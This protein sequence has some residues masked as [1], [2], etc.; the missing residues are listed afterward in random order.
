MSIIGGPHPMTC[1]TTI[2]QGRGVS[3][4]LAEAEIIWPA[5]LA[6]AMEGELRPVYGAAQ[7]WTKASESLRAGMASFWSAVISSDLVSF[8]SEAGRG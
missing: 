1:D 5:I 4:A 6:D 3:F 2:L 7:R 8:F